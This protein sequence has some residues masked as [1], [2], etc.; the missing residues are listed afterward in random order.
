MLGVL[1]G[2]CALL[3]PKSEEELLAERRTAAITRAVQLF[4]QWTGVPPEVKPAPGTATS[5]TERPIRRRFRQS[6]AL[7][8]VYRLRDYRPLWF[9]RG[10]ISGAG[11]IA[12][13]RLERARES[14]L[15]SAFYRVPELRKLMARVEPPP[16]RKPQRRAS[17]A[18]P[19]ED[20]LQG[21][22]APAA[23]RFDA[24]LT[25]GML[26]LAADLM[27]GRVDPD[28]MDPEWTLRVVRKSREDLLEVAKEWPASVN[29]VMNVLEPQHPAYTRMKESLQKYRELA[30][31]WN[32]ALPRL[33]RG[34]T[35]IDATSRSGRILAGWLRHLGDLE[36]SG[37]ADPDLQ[38]AS[39][40]KRFQQRHGLTPDGILRE[41]TLDALGTTLSARVRQ[42]ELNLERWRWLPRTL[43][44]RY[45]VVNIA[46]YSL[47]LVD[48]GKERL[49][50]QVLVGKDYL[51]TPVFSSRVSTLS[52]NPTWTIPARIAREELEPAVRKDPE[53][54]SKRG[55]RALRKQGGDWVDVPM[56][57][58]DWSAES[59]EHYRVIFRQEPGPRNPLGKVKMLFPN[60]F[61]V[62]L[63]DS[64]DKALFKGR[65]KRQSSGCL[66]VQRAMSL[67]RELYFIERGVPAGEKQPKVEEDWEEIEAKIETG[68]SWE[69]RYRSD[70]SVFIVYFTAW[71]D[72]D[73]AMQFRKD[74]YGR[75]SVLDRWMKL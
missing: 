40:V 64:P 19:E 68:E 26:Q 55:I 42:L 7:V 62:Y 57:E 69:L 27:W 32:R 45:V 24:T 9:E 4:V 48:L 52:F 25:D 43:G 51:R 16:A 28:L 73:G 17:Q 11:R 74:I 37:T 59:L 54:L 29:E 21:L 10:R 8:E 60:P 67:A 18:P 50:S 31:S 66:R 70:V 56:A 3:S 58:I 33:L 65:D 41:E 22:D 47:S 71:A 44:D 2:G 20:P 6:E 39:A 5:W 53:A 35:E 49:Y 38:L 34:N 14:G 72:R 46:D 61:D 30:R 63:H 13:A 36:E 23:A 75:D 1:A 15:D 12:L